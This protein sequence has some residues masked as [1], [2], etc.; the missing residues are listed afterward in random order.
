MEPAALKLGKGAAF[1][2]REP[3]KEAAPDFPAI[4]K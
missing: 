1:L 4:A 2:S 3:D